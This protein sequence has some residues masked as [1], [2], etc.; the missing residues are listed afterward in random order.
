LVAAGGLTNRSSFLYP[1]K[2][3]KEDAMTPKYGIIR[4]L[5]QTDFDA[6]LKR[7][8]AALQSEGFGVLT[9][10]NV[11]ET[12][13]QKL[14]VDF[15]H[16]QI[17]GACNPPFAH[18]AL[19]TEPLIGLLLPCNV[20][21]SERDEGGTTVAIASPREMFRIVENPALDSVVGEVE[22]K[23]QRVLERL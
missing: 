7:T 12:L 9:E 13:K 11:N 3:R 1:Y 6:A 18:Q 15:K 5:P 8:T 23:L 2:R 4:D 17:L 10:I 20:V 14:D 16:Y 21:V 19:Q 22:A